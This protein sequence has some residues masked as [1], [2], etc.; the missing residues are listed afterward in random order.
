MQ[1][2]P[3]KVLNMSSNNFL[4][5]AMDADIQVCM[6]DGASRWHIC[7]GRSGA[8]QVLRVS[9]SSRILPTRA[10]AKGAQPSCCLQRECLECIDK[11]G[12]GSCGPRGF[13]GTID[14]HLTLEVRCLGHML[15]SAR[16]L[17]AVEALSIETSR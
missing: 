17:G 12:V 2:V 4:G 1:G 14:V 3:E 13:F 16:A 6:S 8:A 7:S 15:A 9:L 10:L 11:Y 5:L